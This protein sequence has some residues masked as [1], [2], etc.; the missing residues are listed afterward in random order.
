MPNE[1]SERGIVAGSAADDDGDLTWSK[2]SRAHHSAIDPPDLAPMGKHESRER[3]IDERVWISKDARH[4]ATPFGRI[5]VTLL[6]PSEYSRRGKT[7]L[8]R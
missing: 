5:C 7:R 8:R 3:V 1:T 4:H 6:V 2:G